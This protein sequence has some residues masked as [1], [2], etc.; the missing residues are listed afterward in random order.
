MLG[1]ADS[2]NVSVSAAV[3][4][5]ESRRQRGDHGQVRLRDHRGAGLPARRPPTRR[6]LGASVAIIDRRWFGGGCP[7][8]GCLPRSRCSTARPAPCQPGDLRLVRCVAARDYMVNRP[9]DAAEPDDTGHLNPACR[10]RR[11]GLA[12]APRAIT[13]HGRLAIRHDGDPR[14]RR[15]QHRHRGR[16]R[17]EGPALEDRPDPVLDDRDA[18]L[19]ASCPRAS[20]CSAAGRP[21]ASS[22]RSTSRFDVPT[23][24]IQSGPRL[25]PTDHPRN[26]ETLRAAGTDRVTVRTGVRARGRPARARTAPTSSSSTT[27]RPRRATPSCSPSGAASRS[28]TSGS[29]TTASTPPAERRSRATGGC[30]S[31]TGCGSSATRPAQSC[32]PPGALPGRAGG[33]DGARRVRHARLPRLPR[34]TYT[35]PEASSVGHTLERRRP[36]STRSSSSPTSRRAP[37]ATRSRPRSD[38]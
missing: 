1:V 13:G 17:V 3:L 30:A 15:G 10:G 35:D 18:T 25:A 9:A 38:T 33:P 11:D 21:A 19:R 36:A 29:S 12:A 14:P 26:S 23:T 34:A 8:I 2:L 31:A 32:T 27:A 20:S 5:Y 7:H 24:I 28:R 22:P 37:R 6:E 16:L 4:L